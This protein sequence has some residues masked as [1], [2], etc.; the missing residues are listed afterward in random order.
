MKSKG[1]VTYIP[2]TTM[3]KL[4][5]YIVIQTI[6]IVVLGAIG[7]YMCI[8]SIKL[9]AKVDSLI[10]ENEELNKAIEMKNS[11]ISDLEENCKDLF[12]E[13]QELKFGGN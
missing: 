9:A 12:V 4:K 3:N 8:Q 6:G 2:N 10:L 7:I 11:Q 1:E 13:N 5:R